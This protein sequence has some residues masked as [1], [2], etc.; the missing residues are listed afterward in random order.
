[1]KK[2]TQVESR[3]ITPLSRK[4]NSSKGDRPN[5]QLKKKVPQGFITNISIERE[6]GWKS[7]ERSGSRNMNRNLDV[8]DP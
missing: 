2:P 1:M 6:K 4:R 3:S 7:T 8:E 5:S